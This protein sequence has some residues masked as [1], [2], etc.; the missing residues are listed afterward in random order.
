[1]DLTDFISQTLISIRDGVQSANKDKNLY[2]MNT[3]NDVEFD[4]AVEVSEEKSNQKGGGVAIRVV[5]GKLSSENK[6]RESNIS[7]IKFKVKVKTIIG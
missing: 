2:Q 7:R 1:M 4:I 6:S 3:T 5:E